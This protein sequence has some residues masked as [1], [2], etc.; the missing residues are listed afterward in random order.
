MDHSS[1]DN[2][3]CKH[4]GE[5]IP[6]DAV[7]CTSCGHQ[8]EK[9]EQQSSTPQIALN[10][11]NYNSTAG[12]VGVTKFAISG[13]LLFYAYFWDFLVHIN[14]MRVKQELGFYIYLHSVFVV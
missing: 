13:L 7:I 1:P 6:K 2:K 4:C 12:M 5:K 8:V 9:L 3:F 10:N 11:S 14:F